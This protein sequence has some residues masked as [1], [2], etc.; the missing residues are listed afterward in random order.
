MNYKSKLIDKIKFES[1]SINLNNNFLQMKFSVGDTK[2]EIYGK[3]NI[4][5]IKLSKI[6]LSIKKDEWPTFF[7]QLPGFFVIKIIRNE[8]ITILND[9]F[10][11]YRLYYSTI[12]KKFIIYDKYPGKNIDNKFELEFFK[13]KSYTTPFS[14]FD[15]KINKLFPGAILIFDNFSLNIYDNKELVLSKKSDPNKD[16]SLSKFIKSNLSFVKNNKSKKNILFFSGGRDSLYLSKM[17]DELSI[18]HILCFIVYVDHFNKDNIEDLIKSRKLAKLLDKKL[19][20]IEFSEKNYNSAIYIAQKT[21]PID[22][23][24]PAMYHAVSRLKAKYGN[25]NIINGQSSDSLLAWGITGKG[26]SSVI[27][28]IIIS[29]FYRLLFLAAFFVATILIISIK[30]TTITDIKNVVV[31]NL[32]DIT[33]AAGSVINT[34]S[35]L[36]SAFSVFISST[37]LLY[38][39]TSMCCSTTPS[40][41]ILGDILSRSC[42]VLPFNVDS[43]LLTLTFSDSM[44][45]SS[46]ELIS[47]SILRSAGSIDAG[48]IPVDGVSSLTETTDPGVID[49][50]INNNLYTFTHLK[51]VKNIIFIRQRQILIFI[52]NSL[53]YYSIGF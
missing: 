50:I 17:L 14:T 28:R 32:L 44:K 7:Q 13:K 46:S 24:F 35:F 25:F 41:Y 30:R 29:E 48:G 31:L 15:T 49:I 45:G 42:R 34:I 8:K 43:T 5:Q 6:L 21:K 38:F 40:L 11:N 33:T 3:I 23:S 47:I 20:I 27:Q 19:D 26:F 2:I 22:Y 12:D 51:I 37:F 9:I 10:G 1:K 16:Y 18:D 52:S 36:S 53:Y 4:D 39:S